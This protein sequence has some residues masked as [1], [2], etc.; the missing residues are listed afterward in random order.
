M[1]LMKSKFCFALLGL[2]LL[3]AGS[4]RAEPAPIESGNLTGLILDETGSPLPGIIITVVNTA[5]KNLMPILART[6]SEGMVHFQNLATGLYKLDIKSGEFRSPTRNLIEIFPKKTITVTL[7]L[8]RLAG[9]E[10]GLKPNLGI[11]ALLRN[12]ALK[13]LI[14]RNHPGM[15]TDYPDERIFDRAVFQVANGSN[16]GGDTFSFPGDSWSGMTSSFAV[17]NDLGPSGRYTFAGQLDSGRDSMWRLK[18]SVER[19]LGKDHTLSLAMGYGR[20]SFDQ[21][22]LNLLQNPGLYQLSTDYTTAPGSLKIVNLSLEDN[23][24]LGSF[25]TVTMGTEINRYSGEQIGTLISP[26]IKINFTPWERT[27]FEVSSLAKRSTQ[28]NTVNSFD[29]NMISLASPL[30]IARFD[31]QTLLG[32][33]RYNTARIVHSLDSF[34]DLEISYFNNSL[35]G[36]CIPVIAISSSLDRSRPI[37]LEN[38][39][40]SNQGIRLSL[41]RSIFGN[42]HGGLS[43][44]R[45]YGPGLIDNLELASAEQLTYGN[46]SKRMSYQAIAAELEAYIPQTQTHI[47]A[48]VK[49]VTSRD[50]PIFTIDPMSDLLETGNEGINLFVRQV[51]SLPGETVPF[52]A[53]SFLSPRKIEILFDVRNLLD[54]NTGQIQTETGTITLV[55]NPR[56]IRGGISFNF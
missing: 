47:T 52:S 21:P 8:Q 17:S 51:I 19:S 7:V 53:L 38:E 50:T 3:T 45:G 33:H 15:A 25:L 37:A 28:N 27:I 43:L 16:L 22:S 30:R 34:A 48:L 6:N 46:I 42:F 49:L 13:R 20:M 5:R 40:L 31:N 35:N 54:I 9:L 36:G 32:S 10:E 4:L 18:N 41:Q 14:F 23:F 39:I 24:Q 1:V 55:Q 29:G 44:V 12:S 11:K 56:S 2:L 26:E